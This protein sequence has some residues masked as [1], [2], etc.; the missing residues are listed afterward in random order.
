MYGVSQTI[1]W[2]VSRDDNE[3]TLFFR[4]S[5]VW[6]FGYLFSVSNS[7]SLVDEGMDSDLS[8]R[9]LIAADMNC[10]RFRDVHVAIIYL[11]L[12][13]GGH[14]GAVEWGRKGISHAGTCQS[15]LR[16]TA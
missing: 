3:H 8:G 6:L 14:V 7:R 10:C 5:V 4:E 11:V 2:S 1:R 12:Q 9:G 16:T 13:K 15:V